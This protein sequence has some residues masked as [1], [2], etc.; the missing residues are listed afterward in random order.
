MNYVGLEWTEVSLGDVPPV[1]YPPWLSILGNIEVDTGLEMRM[2][3]RTAVLSFAEELSVVT[4]IQLQPNAQGTQRYAQRLASAPTECRVCVCDD[5][6]WMRTSEE[7]KPGT[8]QNISD[9]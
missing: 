4:T 1:F 3:A 7:N 8:R 2:C 9:S 5:R 6:E